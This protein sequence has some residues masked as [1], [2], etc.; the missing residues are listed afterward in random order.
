[1]FRK[2]IQT[3]VDVAQPDEKSI[4]TYVS[5]LHSAMPKHTPPPTPCYPHPFGFGKEKKGL[6]QEYSMIYKSLNRWL[7]ESLKLMDSQAPLPNDYIDLKSLM[8]DLKAFRLE[9][10]PQKQKDRKKLIYIYSEL[11]V[12]FKIS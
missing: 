9:D 4:I 1:M 6:V 8:A 2:I 5:L 11:Q 7:N 3:D 12:W 10:Y